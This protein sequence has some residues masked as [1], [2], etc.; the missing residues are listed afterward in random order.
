MKDL[1]S[2]ESDVSI[3]LH[4]FMVK[5]RKINL[6][7]DISVQF[8]ID[9]FGLIVCC[10]NRMDYMQANEMINTQFSGWRTIFISTGDNLLEK[11]YEILWDLMRCGYMKWLRTTYPR[12]IKRVL[13]GPDNLGNRIINE[14]LRIWA[15]K[16]K[17]RYLIEDNK[18]A[19]RNGVLR[20]LTNDSSFFDFMPEEMI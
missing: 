10:M 20:E 19:I 11:K 17:F 9:D 3:I 4:N 16:P 7:R 13:N 2:L 6:I 5:H 15:N 8:I 1:R 14:R 12:Q 18:I